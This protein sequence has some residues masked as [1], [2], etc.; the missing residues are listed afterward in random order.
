MRNSAPEQGKPLAASRVISWLLEGDVSIQ[1]QTF[2]DLMNIRKP[3]L[4][5]RIANEGWAARLL[6]LRN[7][8]GHW[9][10]SFYQPKWISTHYTLLELKLLNVSQNNK[11][12]RETIH[13]VLDTEKNRDGGIHPA[14]V[15]GNSDVCVNGMLLN[16][17]SYFR[18]SE[19]ELRSIVDFLLSQKMPDGG[20]NCH[21]NRKG[22]SHSSVHSSLSVLEGILEYKRNGFRYRIKE[23]KQAER[24]S[25][26]F[27]LV[28]RLFRSHRTGN[29]INSNFLKLYYP[30]R[31]YYDI[32][33]AL[34][35]FQDA[36]VAY[37]SRMEEA[38]NVLLSKRNVNGLWPLSTKHPGQ[39]HFDMEKAG[40]PSRWNT[41]RAS[42]VLK[43]FQHPEYV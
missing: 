16:Y 12:I 4:Q 21:S 42:R 2:R 33:K 20:F 14:D 8:Q 39:T 19:R 10:R 5:N 41:L 36:G 9:G 3:Q 29:I 23:L 18:A 28:H 7:Q 40:K 32:L 15:L 30:G 34:D 24:D 35:Y 22:A 31:W 1:F 13:L 26:E 27:L 43:H 17:A 37:D 11:E 25:Q 6:S 38:I